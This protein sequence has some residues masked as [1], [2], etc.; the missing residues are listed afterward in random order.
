[1]TTSGILVTG[2][3]GTGRPV[4]FRSEPVEEHLAGLAAQGVPAEVREVMRHL[5]TEVLDGRDT[6]TTDGAR[7][8]LGREPADVAAHLRHAPAGRS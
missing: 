3:T 6:A 8:V 1:M 4:R 7:R 5:F 2:G